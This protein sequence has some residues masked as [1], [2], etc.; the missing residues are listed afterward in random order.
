VHGQESE[1][2][3]FFLAQTARLREA[4]RLGPVVDLACGRGRHA[5]AAAARGARVIGFDRDR[6]HLR[7]LRRVAAERRLPLHAVRADLEG[8]HG[9]PVRAGTCGAILVFRFLFRPLADAICEALRPSGLLLYETFTVHQTRFGRSPS[10]PSFL[11]AE[12]ELR[13]LFPKLEILEYWE[14]V[15]GEEQPEAVARLVARRPDRG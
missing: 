4:A 1:P 9:I 14:G 11:L 7:R 5:L 3:A 13:E 12:G 6:D 15:T 2:S 8:G 10:N